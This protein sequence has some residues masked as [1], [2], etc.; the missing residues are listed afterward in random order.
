VFGQVC[1]GFL[2]APLEFQRQPSLYL[3]F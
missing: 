1:R 3:R 2:R